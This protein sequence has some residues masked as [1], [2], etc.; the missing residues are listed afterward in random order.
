LITP[1]V[2]VL[3]A[4]FMPD[5]PHRHQA[6]RWLTT[7]LANNASGAM[8]AILPMVAVGFV[9]VVTSSR[10]NSQSTAQAIAFV[11]SILNARGAWM[12][13]VGSEWALLQELCLERGLRGGIISDAWIAAAVRANGLHLVTF[14]TDFRGLLEPDQYTLLVPENN[15][16]EP[17]VTYFAPFL[18][19]RRALAA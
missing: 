5:H 15:L 6:L 16:Q 13:D 2:N 10:G 1:D 11:K 9:R 7:A 17:R 8:L 4:A 3:V 19:E 12:P 14:D 18:R